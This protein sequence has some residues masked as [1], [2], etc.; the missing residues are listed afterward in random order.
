[1]HQNWKEM[2]SYTSGQ[3]Y[4]ADS[5]F[6]MSTTNCLIHQYI[7][8]MHT[9]MYPHLKVILYIRKVILNSSNS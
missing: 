9:T 1:M 7:Y 4:V 2:N 3:A 8:R 5:P 6:N